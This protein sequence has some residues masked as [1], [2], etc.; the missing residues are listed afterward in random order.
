MTGQD[1]D[2][3]VMPKLM[4]LKNLLSA[5]DMAARK[6]LESVDATLRQAAP[7][8]ADTLINAVHQFDFK[9]GIT[10]LE[11]LIDKIES[12]LKTD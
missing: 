2:A 7:A 1:L 3:V 5:R 9:G 4:Q 10:A 12:Q 11:R 8:E 6:V